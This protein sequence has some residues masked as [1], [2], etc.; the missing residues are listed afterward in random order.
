MKKNFFLLLLI[1]V[2]SFIVSIP[3][4]AQQTIDLFNGSDLS[5]WGFVLKDNSKKPEEVFNVQNGVIHISGS[6]SGYMYTLN[7]YDN[8]RLHVEWRWPKEAT[9]NGILLYVQDDNKVWPNSIQCQLKAGEAG[10]FILMNGANLAEYV[11]KKGEARPESPVIKKKNPSSE[12]AVGEWN[13]TDIICDKG[14]ITVFINGVL[15]NKGTK[16]L[17][18]TGHVGLQCEGKDIQFRNVRLTP[19]K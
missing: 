4:K 12:M 7:K 5:G 6:P 19:L 9:N 10:D 14:T 2:L 8:Y 3:A 16:S 18:K 11:T 17:H 1:T 13:N 15:Q